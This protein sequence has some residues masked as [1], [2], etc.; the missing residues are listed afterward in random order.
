MKFYRADGR[1][2][3]L[4]SWRQRNFNE[5]T[6]G[7]KLYRAED[8]ETLKSWRQWNLKELKAVD[9]FRFW[10]LWFQTIESTY[11]IH[12]CL[13]LT[14]KIHLDLHYIWAKV[15]FP[16]G[17]INPSCAPLLPIILSDTISKGG[18]GGGKKTTLKYKQIQLKKTLM[19]NFCL[20]STT[21]KMMEA[22]GIFLVRYLAVQRTRST[23][24]CTVHTS[25]AE[26]PPYSPRL[27]CTA[28][29]SCS[30]C[31]TG[32]VRT[33]AWKEALMPLVSVTVRLPASAPCSTLTIWWLYSTLASGNRE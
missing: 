14:C 29:L 20:F 12:Y 8:S 11:D 4:R 2:E 28:P 21:T 31:G 17:V 30:I 18:G 24:L 1:N 3:T 15:I 13:V 5:L 9:K 16:W 6:A 26:A 22:V 33:T 25:V 7:M 32:M 27:F 23:S 19:Q 10:W